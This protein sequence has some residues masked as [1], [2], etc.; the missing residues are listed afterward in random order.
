M[1][2]LIFYGWERAGGALQG[3]MNAGRVKSTVKLEA[4]AVETGEAQSADV[5]FEFY[6]PRDVAGFLAGAV[7]STSPVAGAQSAEETMCAFVELGAPDVPWRY[8]PVPAA[9]DAWN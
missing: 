6:G 4:R 1:K 7:T 3:V 5:A 8:V 2:D 9:G